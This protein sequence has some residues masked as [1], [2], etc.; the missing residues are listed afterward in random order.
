MTEPIIDLDV[1]KRIAHLS[2]L[3]LPP[4]EE[5]RMVADMTAMLSY[6]HKLFALDVDG[7][8]PTSHAVPTSGVFRADEPA[9]GIPAEE[10][11]RGAPERLGDGFGVPHVIE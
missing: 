1:V 6:V 8:V 7:V 2:R 9:A 10:T 11:L 3:T 5:Q 4:A